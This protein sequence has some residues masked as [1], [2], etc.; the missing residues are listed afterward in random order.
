MR[1]VGCYGSRGRVL[2][3]HPEFTQRQRVSMSQ[4][5]RAELM[6]KNQRVFQ[7]FVNDVSLGRIDGAQ[8]NDIVPDPLYGSVSTCSFV[9][10]PGIPIMKNRTCGV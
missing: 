2:N 5:I 7:C 6:L 4:Q 8:F 9:P 10:L 1:E 3:K